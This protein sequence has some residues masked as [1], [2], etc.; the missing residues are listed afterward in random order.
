MINTF[1][2][3]LC[4]I[5]KF[6]NELPKL[7]TRF[8]EI[9]NTTFRSDEI[10]NVWMKTKYLKCIIT[11][12]TCYY[13][14]NKDCEKYFNIDDYSL[15]ILNVYRNNCNNTDYMNRY[16]IF[17]NIMRKVKEI[18]E[19]LQVLL[20]DII[21]Y[22][23][24]TNKAINMFNEPILDIVDV[25]ISTCNEIALI[26]DRYYGKN[27]FCSCKDG[28]YNHDVDYHIDLDEKDVDNINDSD[29]VS[30]EVELKKTQF[31][32]KK[33]PTNINYMVN[34][35]LVDKF[36]NENGLFRK[37]L[38]RELPKDIIIFGDFDLKFDLN[39]YH[40]EKKGKTRYNL[41]RTATRC[42]IKPSLNKQYSNHVCEC[43]NNPDCNITV[44][45]RDCPAIGYNG[46]HYVDCKCEQHIISKL[47]NDWHY[48]YEL[49][50]D[51]L[52]VNINNYGDC[53]S[54]KIT[55]IN[56]KK[57]IHIYSSCFGII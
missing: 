13:Y 23:N 42:Y 22:D 31:I 41:E 5:F 38:S 16:G 14:F 10:K 19:V 53:T 40:N 36:Y 33:E 54:F 18:G 26:D 6:N 50:D 30:E 24:K 20:E 45:Y 9:F 52:I 44:Y 46:R 1:G 7:H 57:Q 48:V 27:N 32:V 37:A 55:T 34:Y 3:Q 35:M 56:G 11:T 51:V 4:L 17:Y 49:A 12:D 8:N 43:V 39:E 47:A 28:Q 2:Y 21:I 29:Y 25:D 15:F